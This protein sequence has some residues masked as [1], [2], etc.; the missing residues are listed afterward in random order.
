VTLLIVIIALGVA[1]LVAVASAAAAYRVRRTADD[2]VADAV[3]RLA[4]G[5][6]DTIRE[7]TDAVEHSEPAQ[8]AERFA[9]ELAATLDVDEVAERALEAAAAV[10]G[11]D[12]AMLQ[13][14]GP[15]GPFVRS[16]VGLSPE[17]EA[18]VA[19]R[20]PEHDNLRAVGVALRYRIDDAAGESAVL[21]SGVVVPL[22]AEG[23]TIGS[24]GAWTRSSGRELTEAAVDQLERLAL[25]A[26]PA[27][28]NA[29]RYAEARALADLDALTGLHN[30]RYFHE[31]LAREVA[32][33]ARYRRRLA[34]IVI[35]LD[36]FKAVNDR[37]GHLA[38]DGVLAEAAERLRS[39]MRSADVACRVGGDEFAVILP[40]SG[41]E[42]AE[43]LAGRIA[44]AIAARPIA[45]AGTLRLSAG[46]AELGDGDR[47]DDLF[48]RADSALYRAKELGKGRTI[49]A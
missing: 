38:G 15:G 10:P 29:R 7:L 30:R 2:R 34:L 39:V 36:D 3:Q 26:G 32:R 33:A 14:D 27:L 9:P 12:A 22:R 37:V 47:P 25:R 11:V 8:P 43:L 1:A 5:M 20:A 21:R 24:L 6:H 19:L 48:E 31:T 28:E 44:R 23:A 40:E 45:G 13:A 49:G 17:E 35:D 16:S 18:R 4:S 46:V 42:D 41:A